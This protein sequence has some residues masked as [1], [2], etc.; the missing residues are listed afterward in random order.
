MPE[1]LQTS[2]GR[3]L[4][5]SIIAL[6]L[7]GPAVA[8]STQGDDAYE[9]IIV[10]ARKREEPILLV[11]VAVNAF[12]GAQLNQ[13]NV[14]NVNDLQ[15]IAP[16]LFVDTTTGEMSDAVIRIR[17]VGTAGNNPGLEGAVGV[18]IDG[19]YRNRS[20]LA[21]G[22][23]FDVSRVEVLRGP[24]T[25]LFG[26][27]TS[28]GAI[29]IITNKPTDTFSGYAEGT[30]GN[31]NAGKFNG[32][33]NVPVVKGV[34]STRFSGGI[35]RRSGFI[36]E[37]NTGT[38]INN[39]DRWYLRGQALYT[40]TP[41]IELRIIGDYT[42]GNERPGTAI[43][44]INGPTAPAIAFLAAQGGRAFV[45]NPDRNDRVISLD[46][47][48]F[49]L[50]SDDWGI[51]GELNWQ[52]TDNIKLTNIAG[53]RDF[54]SHSNADIDYTAAA[55]LNREQ[56]FK[57]QVLT[58]EFRLSGTS[59][60]L[61]AIKSVDWMAG[62]YYTN[63]KIE[64]GDNLTMQSQAGL[65]Y[66]LLVPAL[67]PFAG[68]WVPGS[69]DFGTFGTTTKS[70]AGFGA[71]TFN[72]TDKLSISGGARYNSDKKTGFGNTFNTNNAIA[73]ALVPGFL[74]PVR[75]YQASLSNKAWTGS[76]SVQYAWT[77]G[78]MTYAS[79]AHGYKAGG[80]NLDR[81]AA[82]IIPVDPVALDPTFRPETV[83][84]YEAGFKS[85]WFDNRLTLN[86]TAFT[87]KYRDFQLLSFDGFTFAITNASGARTRGV[88]VE[89]VV[90]PV[91]GLT[92]NGGVTYADT[93]FNDGVTQKQRDI[94]TGMLA[95]PIE[96]GG[97]HL[98]SA[99][100]WNL[101]GGATY[102]FPIVADVIDGFLHG[103]IYYGSS[104]GAGA[105]MTPEERQD[106]Y[107]LINGR[108]GLRFDGGKYEAAIW[109]RNCTDRT[110]YTIVFN[111]VAQPGSNDTFIGAGREFGGT[112]SVKF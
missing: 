86:V 99:P 92:L 36:T 11:P 12:S 6:G 70:Y 91:K 101:V 5:A 45:A 93:R 56:S 22:D 73:Q 68:L 108:A 3:L 97:K 84:S 21:L 4:G 105:N 38:T 53:W 7:A 37:L 49:D 41:E 43:R 2:A 111:S 112:F 63:E 79:Y 96:L 66:C 16:S 20:G 18:F 30:I 32:W 46:G 80:I 107:A 64:F 25:T 35:A 85:K 89:A 109:C 57:N 74:G 90:S 100:L 110:I 71:L 14:R 31:L 87:A 59:T 23:F 88:E 1:I 102:E 10:T 15:V 52:L 33:V 69:G 17:G 50:D 81:T 26:K 27:N 28:A 54:R 48:P 47:P 62:F 67:C 34:L 44:L 24:Q 76:A 82:G 42:H 77:P 13:S 55:I 8:A 19:V 94:V 72:V 104:R 98:P 40:P 39:E 103:D 106:G 95:A 78:L 51:S 75:D 9:E 60:A 58:E 61:P 65:Y 29:S 83:D